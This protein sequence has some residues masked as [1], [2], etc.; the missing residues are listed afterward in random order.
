MGE[1]TRTAN[2]CRSIFMC[3]AFLVW[4]W[5]RRYFESLNI[6]CTMFVR[7]KHH[8]AVHRA[9]KGDLWFVVSTIKKSS[10]PRTCCYMWYRHDWSHL[11]YSS[12][13][14]RCR[15][16]TFKWSPLDNTISLSSDFLLDQFFLHAHRVSVSVKYFKQAVQNEVIIFYRFPPIYLLAHLYLIVNPRLYFVPKVFASYAVA[17]STRWTLKLSCLFFSGN[18][19]L[20]C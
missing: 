15:R 9:S 1:R 8:T 6:K 19:F 13:N 12:R 20:S 14:N 7:S 3:A 17:F 11:I 16:N 10:V 2:G 18:L 5:K 4:S